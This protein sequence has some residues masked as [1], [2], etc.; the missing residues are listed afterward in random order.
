MNLEDIKVEIKVDTPAIKE[1]GYA[2]E[3]ATSVIK[4]LS[5]P[6][7]FMPIE[8]MHPQHSVTFK[9]DD[10]SIEL[11][12]AEAVIQHSPKKWAEINQTIELWQLERPLHYRVGLIVGI[13]AAVIAF[14]LAAI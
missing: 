12:S 13:T 4:E 3:R 9:N 6:G 10:V 7:Y 2:A 5:L 11:P 1:L 8:K 14:V